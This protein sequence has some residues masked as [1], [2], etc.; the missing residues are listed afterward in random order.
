MTQVQRSLVGLGAMLA[1]AGGLGFAAWKSKHTDEEKKQAEEK[2]ST[3]ID[4]D[5]AKATALTVTAKDET[6]VLAKGAEG[7]RITA[8]LEVGAD[9]ETLRSTLTRL[10]SLRRKSIVDEHPTDLAKYGLD[11]PVARLQV[12]WPG[13]SAE[14]SLGDVNDYA[15]GEYARLGGQDA[16][17]L[18]EGNHQP[19]L[20]RG[21]FE[22]RDKRL[23]DI[24]PEQVKLIDVDAPP[25]RYTLKRDAEG[26]K[27][28]A[29]KVEKADLAVVENVLGVALNARATA[30][31]SESDSALDTF[32]LGTPMAS[33]SV[34]GA[35]GK[36]VT[37]GFG[38]ASPT[39]EKREY[40]HASS[41]HAVAQV[42]LDAHAR[43]HQSMEALEDKTLSHV[44]REDVAAMQFTTPK[45]E[46]VLLQRKHEKDDAGADVDTWSVLAPKPGPAKKWKMGQLLTLFANLKGT[47]VVGQAPADLAKFGLDKPTR[48]ASAQDGNGKSLASITFGK[49]ENGK[50]YAVASG[51][52]RIFAVDVGK[53]NQFPKSGDDVVDEPPAQAAKN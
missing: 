2:A 39:G 16:V 24:D 47:A 32:G 12:T 48:E 49:E 14:L 6:T 26:W 25:D 40:A 5:P 15:G 7:W 41:G 51:D 11:R 45:G 4:F 22:L 27:V 36:S 30:I 44:A 37:L 50:V 17:I 46:K 18:L 23:M 43:L 29:P 52:P 42:P 33:I 21:T 35:D 1:I 38:Q 13:G 9:P 20:A 19:V 28:I 53:A 10:S 8:P 3:V 31:A 34:T